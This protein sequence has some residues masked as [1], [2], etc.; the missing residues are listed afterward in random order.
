MHL[1]T[2]LCIGMSQSAREVIVHQDGVLKQKIQLDSANYFLPGGG[3]LI[4]GQEQDSTFGGFN[5]NQA[6]RCD[7]Y[8]LPL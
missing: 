2:H 3:S 1:Q 5:A 7:I 4:F 8:P 6:F